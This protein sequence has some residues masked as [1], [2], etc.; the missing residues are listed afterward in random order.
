MINEDQTTPRQAG[1]PPNQTSTCGIVVSACLFILLTILGCSTLPGASIITATITFTNANNLLWASQTNGASIELNSDNRAFTNTIVTPGLEIP[2]TLSSGTNI[3]QQVQLTLAHI[4]ANPFSGVIPYSDGS[5]YIALRGA[6]D[7]A[8]ALTLDPTDWALVTMSTQ[9]VGTGRTLRLP[10]TVEAG[11]NQT[12]MADYLVGALELSSTP[13]TQ[14]G[15]SNATV[16]PIRWP[17]GFVS[18][19]AGTNL[20]LTTTSTSVVFNASSTLGDGTVTLSKLA[21]LETDQ[22]IGR[23]ATNTGVPQTTTIT[24]AARSVLDDT[25]VS[26]MVNTLGGASS[27][28][29]GGLVRESGPTFSGAVDFGSQVIHNFKSSV[30]A[31]TGTTYTMAASDCGKVVTA[32]NASAVTITFTT[33]FPDGCSASI[34]QLGSGQVTIAVTGLTIRNRSGFTKCAGQYSALTMIRIGTDLWLTGDGE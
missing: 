17:T 20:T 26:E 21:D 10:L 24:S 7:Q 25:T 28:G 5:T 16:V 34:L 32:S 1:L 13:F 18:L 19:E 12:L 27:T 14:L 2:L 15:T 4:A 29:T 33:S 8:M 6:T 3:A 9:T 30:N 31:Q 23:I 11:A 22:F